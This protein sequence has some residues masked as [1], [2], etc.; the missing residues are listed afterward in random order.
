MPATTRSQSTVPTQVVFKE[1]PPATRPGRK[2]KWIDLLD[3][4][5]ANPGDFGIIDEDAV[6]TSLV[7]QINK[8]R[9]GGVNEG[10]FE[11]TSR[12]NS[13]GT[14]TIYARYLG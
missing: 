11:A 12:S 6:R 13:D 3:Q 7:T 2:S 8:G 14:Y 1:P 4:L 9:I 5:R 10:E